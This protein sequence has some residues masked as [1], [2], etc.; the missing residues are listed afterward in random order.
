MSNVQAIADSIR[1][2]ERIKMSEV[3]AADVIRTIASAHNLPVQIWVSGDLHPSEDDFP[4]LMDE[5]RDAVKTCAWEDHLSTSIVD[6][7]DS[8]WQLVR[9]A[10]EAAIHQ[11]GF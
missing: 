11:L 2:F 4:G 3:E 9:E 5:Q 1:N 10:Q 6:C 8:D 7:N